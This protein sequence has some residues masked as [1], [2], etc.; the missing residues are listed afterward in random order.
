MLLFA[1]AGI[2][3]GAA[4]LISGTLRRQ[5]DKMKTESWWAGLVHKI[6]YRLV[7]IGALLPDIIDKPVGQ[8]FFRDFFGNGRIFAHTL[9]FLILITGIG[10][11]VYKRFQ[12]NWFL[13]IAFGVL[14]H[15][16]LD[17][18]WM[19]SRTLLWPLYGF[20]FYKGEVDAWFAGLWQE[21]QR[22]VVYLSELIGFLIMVWFFLSLVIRKKLFAFIKQGTF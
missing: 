9:L 3:L 20:D 2:T 16:V 12:K 15:L 4:T 21:F 5:Q 1:H 6:D 10:W 11:F 13:V 14:L 18:M 17:Q 7:L 8:F 19:I 22:P